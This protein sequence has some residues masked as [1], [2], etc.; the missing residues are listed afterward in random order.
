MR[1]AQGAPQGRN[2]PCSLVWLG[3]VQWGQLPTFAFQLGRR[4]PQ[5]GKRQRYIQQG[6]LDLLS[7]LGTLSHKAFC[8]KP[9]CFFVG[10]PPAS[11]FECQA[12]SKMQR[13]SNVGF[14]TAMAMLKS[15]RIPQ[16]LIAQRTGTPVLRFQ[17][18]RSGFCEIQYQWRFGCSS[19]HSGLGLSQTAPRK[20]RI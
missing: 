11:S 8:A 12:K 7:R 15:T 19:R 9:C 10:A 16:W 5:I 18:H 17:G 2:S 4:F 3:S 6:I 14:Q 1:D 20:L 13:R